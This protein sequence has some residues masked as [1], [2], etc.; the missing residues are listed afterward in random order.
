MVYLVHVPLSNRLVTS[1]WEG[2]GQRALN[3]GFLTVARIW[4]SNAADVSVSFTS[5][6][7]HELC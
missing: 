7:K 2:T 1:P 3:Q 4:F 6:G 5:T